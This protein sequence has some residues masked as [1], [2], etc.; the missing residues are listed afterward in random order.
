MDGF[1]CIRTCRCNCQLTWSSG[2][3]SI[4]Q[5]R[6]K[7]DPKEKTRPEVTSGHICSFPLQLVYPVTIYWSPWL[8]LNFLPQIWGM[9]TQYNAD[10]TVFWF[11]DILECE[12]RELSRRHLYVKVLS[13]S[14]EYLDRN[15]QLADLSGKEWLHHDRVSKHLSDVPLHCRMRWKRTLSVCADV[16]IELPRPDHQQNPKHSKI[17]IAWKTGVT[18][19]HPFIRTY[20]AEQGPYE[21]CV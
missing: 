18:M 12:K 2:M 4:K 21:L 20:C 17:G 14:L 1:I 11:L 8:K 13:C 10:H 5:R 6:P 16:L 7:G 19:V 15:G 3:L 9:Q